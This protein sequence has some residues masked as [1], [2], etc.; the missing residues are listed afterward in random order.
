MPIPAER[1]TDSVTE[2]RPDARE[3]TVGCLAAVIIVVATLSVGGTLGVRWVTQSFA[4]PEL[5]CL[6]MSRRAHGEFDLHPE[7]DSGS[8]CQEGESCVEISHGFWRS[9]VRI[10]DCMGDAPPEPPAVTAAT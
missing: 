2:P 7:E 10:T 1:K 4:G 9:S 3:M 5:L 8:G 6:D